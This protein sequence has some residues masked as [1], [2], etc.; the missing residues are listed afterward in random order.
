MSDFTA[1]IHRLGYSATAP[2]YN[3][4]TAADK[5]TANPGKKYILHYKNAATPTGILKVTDQVSAAA[6]PPGTTIAGGAYDFQVTASLGASSE[7]MSQIDAPRFR[8]A[9]GAI[10]LV[11]GTPTTL[12]VAIIEV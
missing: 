7:A 3:V 8:D 12:T 2:I 5:F 4:C 1:N 6:Q 10:N 11:N 9:T